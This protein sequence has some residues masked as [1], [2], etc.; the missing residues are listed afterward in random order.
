MN[1]KIF[2]NPPSPECIRCGKC[3]EVCPRGAISTNFIDIRKKLNENLK[4]DKKNI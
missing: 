1:V 4:I 3:I 2:Q